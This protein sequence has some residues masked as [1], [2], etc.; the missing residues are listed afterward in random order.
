MLRSGRWLPLTA[1]NGHPRGSD[2]IIKID[3]A[4]R[5]IV[6]DSILAGSKTGPTYK[7]LPTH[8]ITTV[9]IVLIKLVHVN[10]TVIP[11]ARAIFRHIPAAILA[12]WCCSFPHAI[13]TI[14]PPLQVTQSCS[15]ASNAEAADKIGACVRVR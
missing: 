11:T 15:V 1:I 14:Q 5:A 6:L 13:R 4:E 12:I 8:M 9:H 10:M 3:T 2:K 7:V